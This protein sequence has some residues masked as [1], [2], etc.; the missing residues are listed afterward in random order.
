MV[1][2]RCS[3]FVFIT[4][5]ISGFLGLGNN[6]RCCSD[7][8]I[9]LI[10]SAVF[11]FYNW[12]LCLLLFSRFH[13]YIGKNVYVALRSSNSVGMR[14]GRNILHKSKMYLSSTVDAFFEWKFDFFKKSFYKSFTLRFREST[15]CVEMKHLQ[16]LYSF[17]T[18]KKYSSNDTNSL[19]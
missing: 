3:D 12:D 9:P 7:I 13:S 14:K 6:K 1:Q 10:Q 5:S 8:G 16:Y 19:F 2:P 17:F 18:H 11:V 4:K 15:S